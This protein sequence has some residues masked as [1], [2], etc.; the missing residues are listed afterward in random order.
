MLEAVSDDEEIEAE[1]LQTEE[2]NSSISSAKGKITER[3]N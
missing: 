2:I 3:L 1:T